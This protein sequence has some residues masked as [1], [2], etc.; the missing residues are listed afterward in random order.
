MPCFVLFD[1]MLY[2]ASVERVPGGCVLF[3]GKSADGFFCR[4]RPVPVD[5]GEQF[6]LQRRGEEVVLFRRIFS[7]HRDI[8]SDFCGNSNEGAALF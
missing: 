2:K 8:L 7:C 6:L 3:S 4:E 1:E 5:E